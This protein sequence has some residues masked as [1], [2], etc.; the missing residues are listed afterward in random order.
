MQSTPLTSPVTLSPNTRY[1]IVS[2]ETA[3]TDPLFMDDSTILTTGVADVINAISG[4]GVTFLQGAP[5]YHCFGPLSFHY[6]LTP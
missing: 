2:Q 5:G 1:Y 6:S 4:D 3:G